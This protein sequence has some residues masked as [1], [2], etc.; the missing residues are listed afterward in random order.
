[1][2]QDWVLT[3]VTVQEVV[4]LLRPIVRKGNIPGQLEARGKH[5]DICFF[6]GRLWITCVIVTGEGALFIN[7]VFWVPAQSQ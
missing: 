6:K 4:F 2:I 5:R 7:A 1:M 3:L